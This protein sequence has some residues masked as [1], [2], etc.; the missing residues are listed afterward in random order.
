MARIF[1][2]KGSYEKYSLDEQQ[3]L[4]LKVNDSEKA[5]TIDANAAFKSNCVT[6]SLDGTEDFFVSDKIFGL[7]GDSMREFRNKMTA[8]PPPKTLKEVIGALIPP[9]VIKRGKNTEG[10][11]LF[12]GE[13]IAEEEEEEAEEEEEIDA[14]QLFEA[15]TGEISIELVTEKDTQEFNAVIGNSASLVGIAKSENINK[16]TEFL[17]EIKKVLD[18]YETSE[19]FITARNQ[20]ENTYKAARASL[21][22]RIREEKQ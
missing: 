17:D 16:D 7:V 9:K 14:D 13:E 22:K 21:K 10:A 2:D 4:G 11:E 5:I 1:G 6:N 8:K 19:Q 20:I 12:D 15:L 3:E 18:K